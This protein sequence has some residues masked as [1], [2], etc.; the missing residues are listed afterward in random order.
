MAQHKL[1]FN[2]LQIKQNWCRLRFAAE[3]SLSVT[4]NRCTC[5]KCALSSISYEKRSMTPATLKNRSATEVLTLVLLT[6]AHMHFF[7]HN[8]CEK[9]LLNKPA[10]IKL[11]KTI[12]LITLGI[13]G[14]W[15]SYNVIVVRFRGSWHGQKTECIRILLQRPATCMCTGPT[16][17]FEALR[18]TIHVNLLYQGH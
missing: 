12:P 2:C 9:L 7:Y 8:G 10:R 4:Q 13:A 3:S 6:P 11:F 17:V 1:S 14:L 18:I 15:A 16:E 5:F